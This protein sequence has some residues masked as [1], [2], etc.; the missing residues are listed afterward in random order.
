[1]N[2]TTGDQY[3]TDNGPECVDVSDYIARN[4]KAYFRVGAI[5]WDGDTALNL[6]VIAIE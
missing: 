3:E 6:G 2:R 1:M 4:G 5:R